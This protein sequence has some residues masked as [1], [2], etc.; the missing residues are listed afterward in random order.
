MSEHKITATSRKDEGKGASRRLRHAGQVP[1]VVYGGKSGPTSIQLEHE[2]TWQ[3][4]QNE[5]FYSSILDLDALRR[6]LAAVDD[7][8]HE[9]RMT[10]AAARTLPLVLAARGLDGVLVC[11]FIYSLCLR[12]TASRR[13]CRLSRDQ[14]SRVRQST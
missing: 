5:W 6:G 10:K 7:G 11:H 12:W 4:S 1:A 8:R 13:R 2:K 14:E 9:V 3:A